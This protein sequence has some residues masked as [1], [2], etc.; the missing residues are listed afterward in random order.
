MPNEALFIR[1]EVHGGKSDFI[2]EPRTDFAT[3]KYTV[4]DILLSRKKPNWPRK[5]KQTNKT[6][7]VHNTRFW[8]N[9]HQVRSKWKH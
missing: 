4:T 1:S 2:K 3:A 7:I 6:I 5:T 9:L 8:N